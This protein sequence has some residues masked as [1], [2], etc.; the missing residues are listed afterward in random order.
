MALAGQL[1]LVSH[2]EAFGLA[3]L[4]VSTVV[5]FFLPV[6]GG[7]ASPV[8]RPRSLRRTLLHLALVSAIA[9]AARF[10]RFGDVPPGLWAD[11]TEVSRLALE[12]LRGHG[13]VPWQVVPHLEA[14]WGYLWIQ[15]LALKVF[16]TGVLGVRILGTLAGILVAPALYV[17]AGRFLSEESALLVGGLWGVSFWAL[18]FGRW[19]H[20]NCFT[21]LFFCLGM[22]CV[23]DGLATGRLRSWALSGVIVGVAPYFYAANRALLPLLLV[24]T[25]YWV[26]AVD[27]SALRRVARGLLAFTL[28]AAPLLAPLV[29]C[30]LS[31]PSLYLER[32]HSVS[33]FDARYTPDPWRKLLSNLG[34]Y[35]RALHYKGDSILRHNML[36]RP[37]LN[38]LLAALFTVGLGRALRLAR[39]P[40]AF[41]A[42]SWVGL[43]YCAGVLTT[44]APNVYRV[45]GIVPGVLLVVGLGFEALVS[46]WAAV[47][48]ARVRRTVAAAL[49]FLGVAAVD[50]SAYFGRFA[51]LPE[52]WAGF[53]AAET[54]AGLALA[55]LSG[56][57]TVYTDFLNNSTNAVLAAD[58]P[59]EEL[60][61]TD[62]LLAPAHSTVPTLW[63]LSPYDVPLASFLKQ[64]YPK[65]EVV[66]ESSPSGET[67]FA[68]VAVGPDANRNGLLLERRNGDRAANGPRTRPVVSPLAPEPK[69][70]SKPYRV[71]WYGALRTPA[72]GAYRLE[73]H[74]S[75]P[76]TLLL[77]GET[78][79]SLTGS[80]QASADLWL[81][82]GTI[83]LRL[84]RT[85]V[86]GPDALEVFWQ[87]PG[88][89][90]L[91]PLPAET[92]AP[93]AIP[94]GGL[95]ALTWEGAR[96]TGAPVAV[97]HDPL[98]LAV[99]FGNTAI[100]AERWIGDLLVPKTGTYEIVLNS[101]DGSRLFLDGRLVLSHWILDAG[102]VK[103]TLEL[104]EGRHPLV[105]EF[106]DYGGSRWFEVRWKPP[107]GVEER[108][109]ATVLRWRSTQLAEALTRRP[110][111]E[112]AIDSTDVSG[113]RQTRVKLKAARLADPERP[114]RQN[115]NALGWILKGG[116]R[117]WDRGI[118]VA[119]STSLDFELGGGWSRLTGR[120]AVDRDTWGDGSVQFRLRGDGRM[121]FEQRSPPLPDPPGSFDV[122]VAGVRVLTLE[123]EDPND[124]KGDFADWLEPRLIR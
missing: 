95:L 108:V 39:R 28:A 54:R 7:E 52:T 43:F 105:I 94:E 6:E 65:A 110:E 22:T 104:R 68:S 81:P 30:Y 33:I 114:A 41:L 83:P 34:T 118:G 64:A 5:A 45:F 71:R 102:V 44:E 92:T 27:R 42:L 29:W 98:L 88:A 107:G 112:V 106:L 97:R 20:G 119:G 57:W 32:T 18:N 26:L 90:G 85:V 11:D 8:S 86:E 16:G 13:A 56:P 67:L 58:R 10:Y 77:N 36:E 113:D 21:P 59:Q 9:A 120:F 25:A 79:L 4:L 75:N 3:L 48:H 23:W 121:L 19:G 80:G 109:P 100:S 12:G 40:G 31:N 53:R 51:V 78:I 62:H 116:V 46:P 17:L 76:T 117:M 123:V 50:L 2:H 38:V 66:V 111:P 47:P 24:F 55:R 82:Q 96:F 87:P 37:M 60:R 15:A 61:V 14:A 103:T 72:T 122:S 73:L 69:M 84:E 74:S 124:P 115:A 35:A 63:I 49:V 93:V 99:R 101:D 91:S 1:L 89:E 70:G